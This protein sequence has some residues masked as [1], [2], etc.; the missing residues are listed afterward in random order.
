MPER[1]HY[2][3]DAYQEIIRNVELLVPDISAASPFNTHRP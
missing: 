3:E 1:E 2:R